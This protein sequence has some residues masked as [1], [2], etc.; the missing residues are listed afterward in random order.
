MSRGALFGA[1][2]LILG[3]IA[4]WF[5]GRA[6]AVDPTITSRMGIPAFDS[7][8]LGGN[9]TTVVSAGGTRTTSTSGPGGTTQT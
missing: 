1:L 6:G 2:G 4:A 7:G 9:R 8:P 3:A 5:G